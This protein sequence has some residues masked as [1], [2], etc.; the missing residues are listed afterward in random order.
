VNVLRRCLVSKR[1]TLSRYR[2]LLVIAT[3][4]LGMVIGG[5]AVVV[6]G[7]PPHDDPRR[8]DLLTAQT[9]FGQHPSGSVVVR[10]QT[11]PCVLS[12]ESN[13][14]PGVSTLYRWDD[15][16]DHDERVVA[17]FRR[18]LQDSGWS[19]SVAAADDLPGRK[20]DGKKTV[21]DRELGVQIS[22][23]LPWE[24]GYFD[25]SLAG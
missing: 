7:R 4:L 21:G 5:R 20:V 11:S 6:G 3:L 8:C 17:F 18:V 22:T 2:R 24:G 1:L 10:R 12:P 19:V 14:T 16:R 9:V 15:G 23:S 13:N 25:V